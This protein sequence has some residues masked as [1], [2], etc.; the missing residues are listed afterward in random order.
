MRSSLTLLFRL[1][2][3]LILC[4]SCAAVPCREWQFTCIKTPDPCFSSSRLILRTSNRFRGLDVE[5]I[6]TANGME[7][8]LNAFSLPFSNAPDDPSKTSVKITI[9]DEVWVILAER[10]DGGQRLLI[11]FAVSQQ[12]VAALLNEQDVQIQVGRYQEE[13]LA[14]GFAILYEKME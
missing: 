8:H 3:L 12:V 10:L 2:I 13:L 5:F 14:Q 1:S 9:E 6:Q 7:M 11:P 4:T